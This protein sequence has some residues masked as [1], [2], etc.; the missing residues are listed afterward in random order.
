M[1]AAGK[2]DLGG[3]DQGGSGA[4]F[5]DR[6]PADPAGTVFGR[7]CG[8]EKPCHA[9]IR[10]L[11]VPRPGGKREVKTKKPLADC[12]PGGGIEIV[13]RLCLVP[14][15]I[16]AANWAAAPSLKSEQEKQVP[17]QERRKLKPLIRQ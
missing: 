7:E 13:R 12:D 14:S 17:C 11:R 8:F 16:G 3:G 1:R 4:A 2:G 6:A 9:A 15:V 5:Q 10:R